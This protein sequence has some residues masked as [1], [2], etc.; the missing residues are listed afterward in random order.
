MEGFRNVQVLRHT[1]PSGKEF[2]KKT[3]EL[4]FRH[5][6]Y[7]PIKYS[8]TSVTLKFTN[9]PMTTYSVATAN[10]ETSQ[11][12]HDPGLIQQSGHFCTT[13]AG[14]D[15]DWSF[16]RGIRRNSDLE[17]QPP[18]EVNPDPR[19]WSVGDRGSQSDEQFVW[20]SA[21][22]GFRLLLQQ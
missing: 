20:L 16:S 4:L 5:N 7:E 2:R 1:H 19:R 11:Q 13:P 18:G 21:R 17:S 15:S 22:R 12:A 6:K 14:N 10:C 3:F 8:N 9:Q